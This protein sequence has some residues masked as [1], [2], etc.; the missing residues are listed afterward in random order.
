MGV[1]SADVW[2]LFIEEALYGAI[3]QARSVRNN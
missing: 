2:D 1:L 3:Y